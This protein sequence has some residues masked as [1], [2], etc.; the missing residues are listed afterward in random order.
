MPGS[1]PCHGPGVPTL[2]APF[3][4]MYAHHPDTKYLHGRLPLVEAFT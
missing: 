2:S 1:L 4:G 3:P